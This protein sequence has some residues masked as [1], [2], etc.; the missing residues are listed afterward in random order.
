MSRI[1]LE[2]K[3]VTKT[4]PAS[5]LSEAY[6]TLRT[7]ILFSS[8]DK[9]VQTI[10]VTSPNPG[11]GK[12]TTIANLAVTY[13]HEGKR[14]LVV[15]GDL[16]KPSLHYMFMKSNRAGLTNALFK[17]NAWQE[18]VQET[19]VPG[20][21][22]MT[23]GSV[24]PNPNEILSSQRI[25]ELVAQWREHYDVILFDSPPL[26]AVTDGLIL[27]SLSDGVV[28]VVKSGKTKLGAARKMLNQLEFAKAKVLGTV[29]NNKKSGRASG[30]LYAY[31]H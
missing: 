15:D 14:T 31:G 24:P 21:D 23:S 25:Q 7:N 1:S 27:S 16:R 17:D 3:L 30:Y 19:D 11:D 22:L 29:L 5:P 20:L 9:P 13:A 4:N 28:L 10:V 2:S 8:I 12:T 18:I 26:L 6:R